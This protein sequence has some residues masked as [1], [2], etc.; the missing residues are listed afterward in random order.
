MAKRE[1][2]EQDLQTIHSTMC[3]KAT[4]PQFNALMAVAIAHDLNPLLRQIHFVSRFDKRRG[5]EVW[6]AMVSIDGLRSLAQRSGLY[7]GQDEPLWSYDDKGNL[8][9]CKISVYRKDWTRPCVSVCF[10]SESVQAFNGTPQGLWGTKPK[11]MLAKVTEALALR[12]AFP[13]ATAGLYGTE[14]LPESHATDAPKTEVATVHAE[15]TIPTFL[16]GKSSE[17]AG[18]GPVPECIVDGVR[19]LGE[20]FTLSEASIVWNDNVVSL[21]SIED[22]EVAFQ[23]LASVVGCSKANLNRA[24][25]IEACKRGVEAAKTVSDLDEVY[26]WL[27]KETTDRKSLWGVGPAKDA[28]S[29]LAKICAARKAKLIDSNE[30][31][32]EP[33]SEIQKSDR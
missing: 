33:N 2:T 23:Y 31:M 21:K 13:E 11:L 7:A 27:K 8:D 4:P 9:S 24:I 12:K 17:V 26:R 15:P 6:N 1:Y 3:E 18:D 29:D 30:R 10:W 28:L 14:E 25:D 22:K 32:K 5:A 19:E 16:A 20:P